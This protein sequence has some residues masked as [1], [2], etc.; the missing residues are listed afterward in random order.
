MLRIE[1][2]RHRLRARKG[3]I[4]LLGAAS[5]AVAVI[6]LC[7]TQQTHSGSSDL[8]ALLSVYVNP[9]QTQEMKGGSKFTDLKGGASTGGAGN[10]VAG[11]GQGAGGPG[12]GSGPGNGAGQG[13]GPNGGGHSGSGGSGSPSPASDDSNSGGAG[14]TV[15]GTDQDDDGAGDDS[16][17]AS[18]APSAASSSKSSPF[19]LKP[20][21][22]SY[23]VERSR[24]D[25]T[26]CPS[27]FLFG[28]DPFSPVISRR[29]PR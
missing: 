28:S 21:A 4:L 2:S 10:T 22:D 3:H 18:I 12:D 7:S 25:F 8:S 29:L 20:Y 13:L 24:F 16:L 19:D 11:T 15:A 5:V 26:S 6:L 9:S 27:N 14:N 23:N 17:P 1:E